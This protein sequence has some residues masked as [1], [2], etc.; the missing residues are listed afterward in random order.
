MSYFFRL[1][2]YFNFNTKH[3]LRI[4]EKKKFDYMFKFDILQ[5]KL[6]QGP[7]CEI[8]KKTRLQYF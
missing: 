8:H 4:I 7:A 2:N 3:E 5:V 1:E 6:E